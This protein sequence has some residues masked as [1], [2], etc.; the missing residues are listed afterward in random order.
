MIGT[1]NLDISR[2][3]VSL[4][5]ADSK[6]FL[7]GLI[8]ADICKSEAQPIYTALLSPQGKYLYDFFIKKQKSAY[9]IDIKREAV[10]DFIKRLSLYKLRADI[11]IR[12]TDYCVYIGTGKVPQDAHFDPRSQELG[13]RLIRSLDKPFK[14]ST[15]EKFSFEK[16]KDKMV[17]LCI[18][19]TGIEL[20]PNETY[21]LE[22]G[23]ENIGGVDFK[24]GCYVGQEVTARMHHKTKL[25]KGLVSVLISGE[26]PKLRTRIF[27]SV[28][29]DIGII[30]SISGDKAIAHIK[31]NEASHPLTCGTAKLTFIY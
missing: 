29:K 24:K 15:Y 22:A 9:L 17:L 19:E 23:F 4:E 18:P 5:G 31:F 2:A 6:K 1:Y 13:W 11:Q 28:G 7:Q 30:Y 16:Y 25:K 27:N 8:T 20:I 10:Q 3:V 14:E 12:I 26:I 21:I